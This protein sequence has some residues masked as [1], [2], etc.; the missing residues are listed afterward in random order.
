MNNQNENTAMQNKSPEEIMDEII[1]CM[2][3]VE[4]LNKEIENKKMEIHRIATCLKTL[5]P[6]FV[7]GLSTKTGY[8]GA[9][10]SIRQRDGVVYVCESAKPFGSWLKKKVEISD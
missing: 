8:K 2:K 4:N 7:E 6:K 9:Y 10:Y 1:N 5:H 3:E